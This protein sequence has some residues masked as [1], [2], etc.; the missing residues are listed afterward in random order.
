MS[1]VQTGHNATGKV[2]QDKYCV[3][4]HFR[5]SIATC[6]FGN[7]EL[8]LHEGSRQYN[9]YH[10]L[11]TNHLRALYWAFA[12]R[13]LTSAPSALFPRS[14]ITASKAF[15]VRVV[16]SGS[17]F[18]KN[19]SGVISKVT[20]CN[21]SFHTQQT[22]KKKQSF[23]SKTWSSSFFLVCRTVKTSFLSTR[24]PQVNILTS[25]HLWQ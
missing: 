3:L 19:D 5:S 22:Q 20:T 9:A 14:M 1:D 15:T 10:W 16:P 7:Q 17:S 23:Q 4:T 13:K 8:W 25:K 24:E 11:R 21:L 6:R 2:S 12:P 18:Q